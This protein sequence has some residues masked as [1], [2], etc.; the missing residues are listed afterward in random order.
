MQSWIM[1]VYFV[2][3]VMWYF[4]SLLKAKEDQMKLCGTNHNQLS[5]QTHFHMVGLWHVFAREMRIFAF[6]GNILDAANQLSSYDTYLQNF[7]FSSQKNWN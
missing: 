3:K 7:T 4:P 5:N 1:V 2:E 6:F